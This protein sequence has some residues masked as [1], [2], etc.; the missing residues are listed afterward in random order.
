M[1]TIEA[2]ELVRECLRLIWAEDLPF[3]VVGEL[4]G[5]PPFSD[6]ELAFL[7]I[8]ANLAPTLKLMVESHVW[9]MQ[10]GP[11]SSLTEVLEK[12]L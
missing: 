7:V 4:A 8:L 1:D 10:H 11:D 2:K 3:E 12:P 5:T 9:A 6:E